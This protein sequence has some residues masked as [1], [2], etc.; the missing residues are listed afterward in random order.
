MATLI[1]NSF[2]SFDMNDEE[3]AIGSIFTITQ[4]QMLQNDLAT[5][6]EEMLALEF[7]P[8][9]PIMYTQQE[10]YKRGQME[11]LRHMLD[12]SLNAI[13]ERTLTNPEV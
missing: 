2:A 8:T 1:P 13:E 5:A 10:A 6:A 12:R 4:M 7:D 11:L 3:V 9:C